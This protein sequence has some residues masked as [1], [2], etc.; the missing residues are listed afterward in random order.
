MSFYCYKAEPYCS[1][2]E[3]HQIGL[4]VL[5][6]TVWATHIPFAEPM[7]LTLFDKR[8]SLSRGSNIDCGRV[9]D[10]GRVPDLGV[11]VRPVSSPLSVWL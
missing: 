4:L 5:N 8:C 3:T 6:I 1:S 10:E 2:H 9:P 7:D 11:L